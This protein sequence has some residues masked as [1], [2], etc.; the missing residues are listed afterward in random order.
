MSEQKPTYKTKSNKMSE[1]RLQHD[2]IV[3]FSRQ[4]PQYVDLLFEQNNDTYSD[5]NRFNRIAKGMRPGLSDLGFVIPGGGYAGIELKVEGK[6]HLVEKIRGQL[7][8][9]TEVLFSG[10][11]FLMCYNKEVVLDYLNALMEH[12]WEYAEDIEFGWN[13]YFW[14]LIDNTNNKTVKV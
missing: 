9:G 6:R 14:N 4:Y 8:W 7:N 3:A 13:T 5:K 12:R 1:S 2:I 10:N 11:N